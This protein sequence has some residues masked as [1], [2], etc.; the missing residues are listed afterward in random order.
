MSAFVPPHPAA[1]PS[2]TGSGTGPPGDAVVHTEGLAKVYPDGTAAVH[3][4]DLS[5]RAGE[6]FALLGPNG[7]GKSTTVGMLTTAVVPTGG[8]AWVGGVDV[9]ARPAAARRIIG[10]VPQHSTLDR[11]LTVRENLVFHGRYFGMRR[12]DARLAA[13]RELDRV[14]LA[15]AADKP[16]GGL[17]GGMAQRLMIARAVLHRPA[18]LFLDEPTT[19]LDPQSRIALHD[20]VRDLRAAGQTTVLITHDMAEADSL[21]DRVAVIDHGRLLALGTPAALKADAEVAT[22]EAVFFH[23]T[24]KELR[25]R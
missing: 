5:V 21:A 2:P 22:L 23:L 3:A 4:L 9:A 12:A 7:A 1:T 16:V 19:G 20:L 17:S 18:V 13:D 15:S 10:V 24:G 8:R 6:V 11:S 25:D 14:A